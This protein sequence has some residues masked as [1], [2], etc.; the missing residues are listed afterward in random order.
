VPFLAD[1]SLAGRQPW[2]VTTFYGIHGFGHLAVVVFFCLSG[3][4]VGGEV[5]REFLAGK[6]QWRKYIVKRVA[7]IYPVYLLALLLTL[8][9]DS[10]GVRYFNQTGIYSG[11]IV[12][13][14]LQTD[15]AARLT[16][17]IG[18]GNVAFLQGILVPPFGTNTPLWSLSY[19]AW[20]YL[21]FPLG[22]VGVLGKMN[23]FR[24]ASLIGA[25]FVMMWLVGREIMLYSLIWLLGLI[26][27]ILS[28]GLM[29]RRVWWPAVCSLL[30]LVAARFNLV[31][32]VPVFLDDAA[33]GCFVVLFIGALGNH[34]IGVPGPVKFHKSLS[35]FSYSLYLVH[36]PLALF[37]SA[38]LNQWFGLKLRAAP[39]AGEIGVYGLV[40]GA[41][42]L[43]ALGFSR[44]TEYHT[45]PIRKLL[46]RIVDRVAGVQ[47]AIVSQ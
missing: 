35:N 24:R 5:V 41:V 42:Y 11:R 17:G 45:F 4:L 32:V 23:M 21:L 29:P 36:L 14:I 26:P 44:I 13:P 12:G 3:Y 47:E 30:V 9:L 40:V 27:V 39:T 19:E 25:L 16:P 28:R 15:F 18:L 34:E 33:L 2:P 22:L 38:T 6:F 43:F 10:I 37:L 1:Y 31:R 20:F 7:R 8:V 46:D